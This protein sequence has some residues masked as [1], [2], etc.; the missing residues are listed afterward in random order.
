MK[1]YWSIKSIPELSA[2]PARERKTRWEAAF[3][4]TRRNWKAWVALLACALIGGFG[5]LAGRELDM[6]V[7]GALLGGALGGFM[8]WQLLV[9]ITRRHYRQILL[10]KPS[11]K[12][13]PPNA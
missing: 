8:L 10:G 12:A 4:R 1:I 5:A 6:G 2:L 3:S 7:A 11:P 9:V 13:P